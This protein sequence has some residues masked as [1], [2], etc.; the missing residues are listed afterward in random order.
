M[1]IEIAGAVAVGILAATGVIAGIFHIKDNWPLY[2][3]KKSKVK[4]NFGLPYDPNCPMVKR[5][6]HLAGITE[7]YGGRV[8]HRRYDYNYKWL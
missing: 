4:D 7:S 5:F 2:P 6:Q 3:K 8:T 1:F